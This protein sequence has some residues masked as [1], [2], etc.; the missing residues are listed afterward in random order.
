MVPENETF[1]AKQLAYD[2]GWRRKNPRRGRPKK[3]V[4]IAIVGIDSKN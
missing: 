3:T 1:E 4:D 2:R